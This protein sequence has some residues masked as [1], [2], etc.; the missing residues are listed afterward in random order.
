MGGYFTKSSSDGSLGS[1]PESPTRASS[2]G[3]C[4]CSVGKRAVGATRQTTKYERTRKSHQNSMSFH[5]FVPF[6][7]PFP[8]LFVSFVYFVVIQHV[9]QSPAP[10]SINGTKTDKRHEASFHPPRVNLLADWCERGL[11]IVVI[12]QQIELNGP[13]KDNC[14]RSPGAGGNRVG[15]P[16]GT[17]GVGYRSR[18]AERRVQRAAAW[19]YEGQARTSNN[20]GCERAT[21][22]GNRKSPRYKRTRSTSVLANPRLSNRWLATA[23]MAD[24]LWRLWVRG[25][26]AILSSPYDNFQ[27]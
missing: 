12:T 27:L 16:S 11:K 18:Q 4:L 5:S 24:G 21:N 1:S 26:I 2:H 3:F 13:V 20:I 7:F 14:R 9:A 17:A 25:T 8:F 23:K 22:S 15:V 6:P 19:H 10:H